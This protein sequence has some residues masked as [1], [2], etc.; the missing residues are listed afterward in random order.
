MEVFTPRD[1]DN[2]IS[3]YTAHHKQKQIIVA[4]RN[5]NAQD[6]WAFRTHWKAELE[7]EFLHEQVDS[8]L[9]FKPVKVVRVTLQPHE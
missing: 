1:C 6:E 7:G 8:G 5:K 4:I 9:L 3:S 2:I